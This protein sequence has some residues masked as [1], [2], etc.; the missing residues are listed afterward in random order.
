MNRNTIVIVLLLGILL[1]SGCIDN[2]TEYPTNTPSGT[3]DFVSVKFIIE[4]DN[5]NVIVKTV[6]IEKGKT[7]LDAMQA[8]GIEFAS[9]TYD[10]MGTFIDSIMGVSGD[11]QYYW[12]LYVDGKYAEASLDNYTLNNDIE[13]KWVYEKIDFSEF[14]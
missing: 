8:S 2:T 14:E 3:T 9:T 6:Q 1:M 10:G 13:L 11:A 5:E 4:K 7:G 12:A